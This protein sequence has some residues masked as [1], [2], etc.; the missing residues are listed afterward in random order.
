[1]WFKH[2]FSARCVNAFGIARN[3][4][5]FARDIYDSSEQKAEEFREGEARMRTVDSCCGTSEVEK[6]KWNK[7]CVSSMYFQ[8]GVLMPSALRE[9]LTRSQGIYMTVVNKKPKS[10]V[11][12]KP[13]CVLWIR[14]VELVKWKKL[15]GISYVVQACIFSQVC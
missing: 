14:V 15:S 7:L 4:D 10:F 6:V 12:A 9:I 1:M 11:R 2:G 8:P 13:E 5:T 3:I